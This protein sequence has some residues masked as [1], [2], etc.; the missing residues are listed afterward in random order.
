[1][2]QVVRGTGANP[3]WVT[4]AGVTLSEAVSGV[5]RMHGSNRIPSLIDRV[6]LLARS[7]L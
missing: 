6:D 5:K 4:A 3:L 2:E 7:T 1:V